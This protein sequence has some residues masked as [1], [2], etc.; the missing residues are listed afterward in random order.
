MSLIR[1]VPLAVPSVPHSSTPFLPS[2]AAKRTRGGDRPED[3]RRVKPRGVDPRAP[4][5]TSLTRVVPRVVPSVT[6]SSRPLLP[7]SAEN[8][9]TAGEAPTAGRGKKSEGEELFAPGL[10]SLSRVVPAAVPSLT[11]SSTPFLPSSAEK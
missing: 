5:L 11:H 2:S 3:G 8:S 9:S 6:H 4:G 10:T 7:S 1:V